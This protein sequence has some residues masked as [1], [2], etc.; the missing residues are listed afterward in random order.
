MMKENVKAIYTVTTIRKDSPNPYTVN[1][2]RCFGWFE[3]YETAEE[4]VINNVT[5]ICE[6][7]YNYAV[8]EKAYEGFYGTSHSFD[9]EHGQVWFKY[10]EETGKCDKIEKPEW[11]KKRFG[12]GIG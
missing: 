7:Y 3:D 12:W 11:A 1:D 10:N 4:H 6:S 2:W 5:D 9:E 8:I